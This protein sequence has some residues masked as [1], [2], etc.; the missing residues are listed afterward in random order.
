M[1]IP[2]GNEENDEYIMKRI[3]KKSDTEVE[4]ET[5][6]NFSFVPML[7]KVQGAKNK[8]L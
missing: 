2:V 4:E 6:G 3:T 1:V 8:F 5:F 7:K